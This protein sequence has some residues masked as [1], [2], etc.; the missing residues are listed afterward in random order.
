[1]NWVIRFR[2]SAE[3]EYFSAIQWYEQARPGLGI[4]FER[5]IQT[6]LEEM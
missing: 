4:D 6:V 1:M 2:T 3:E 5:S